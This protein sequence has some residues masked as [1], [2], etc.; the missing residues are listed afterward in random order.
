MKNVGEVTNVL[1]E[2]FLFASEVL[3]HDSCGCFLNSSCQSIEVRG[4]SG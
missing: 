4:G 1:R 2:R 3:F